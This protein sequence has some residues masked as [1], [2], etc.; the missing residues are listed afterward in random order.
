M[1]LAEFSRMGETERRNYRNSLIAGRMYAIDIQYTAYEGALTRER[2]NVGFGAAAATLGLTTAS[3]LVTAVATKDILTGA[4]GFVTGARAAYD[5]DILFSHSVQWIQS[6]MRARRADIGRRILDGTRL[7]TDQY[8]LALALSDLEAYY[9]A[10][11]FTGGLIST[12][13]TVGADAR[14]S[15]QLRDERI[16]VTFRSSSALDA[17]TACVNQREGAKVRLQKFVA[18][19]RAANINLLLTGQGPV[20]AV[21][22][23]ARSEGIC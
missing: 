7:S 16:Q 20:E 11:T 13:E 6:Q 18:A 1:N 19:P 21:L 12:T 14:F 5:N 17:L 10:G 9:R 8:P 22:A 23:K 2:Q 4:A 15:E 3:G